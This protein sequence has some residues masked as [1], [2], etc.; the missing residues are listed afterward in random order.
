MKKKSFLLNKKILVIGG[1]GYIGSHISK[2][3]FEKGYK[4]TVFD[5]LSSGYK[6]FVKW[7]SFIKGDLKNFKQINN[8]IKKTKPY[9]IFHFAG[10]ISVE[11]SKE[12][13]YLYY[14]NNLF[15]TLNLLEAMKN[16]DVKKII[17]SSSAAVY[18]L[19][20]KIPINENASINPTNPYSRSKYFAEEIIKDYQDL[21]GISFMI[22]R[23]FNAAGADFDAEIG[24]MHQPETHLIPLI[25][26]SI[27]NK[28]PI[29]IF[30][31]D[32]RTK[33]RTAVRDY[34]HVKDLALAH[35]LALEALSKNT[36]NRIINLGTEKGLSVLE[37]IK[38]FESL[39]KIKVNKKICKRRKG[40]VP[41][42]VSSSKL[43]YKL[44]KWKTK[45][46]K[47]DIINTA[48][49][50]YIKKIKK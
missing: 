22:L 44:L 43:A 40:D 45:Y 4:V 26:E 1:A 3:L 35:I 14:Y 13:P 37:I 8:A 31:N 33:D 41:K 16:N 12:K 17:F 46:N 49:N 48:Y 18:G 30:G 32:Y 7:G 20:K 11:E 29:K 9:A 39:K 24:E 50:W 19:Q 36:K 23:Y 15:G 28:K 6:N 38:S 47:R 5:N 27:I 34:I 2:E 10:S 25:V 21:F 42:L